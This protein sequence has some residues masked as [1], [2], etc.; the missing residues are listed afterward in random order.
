M[1]KSYLQLLGIIALIAGVAVGGV[2][3]GQHYFHHDHPP[4]THVKA[5]SL[6][7]YIHAQLNITPEQDEKLKDMER[8]YQ[9]KVIY[10]EEKL[11]LANM[12]L[13]N[14][15]KEEKR[16]GPRVEKAIADNH[17]TMGELQKATMQ[18]L[19]K[20]Q[21]VLTEEQNQKM[22]RIITDALYHQP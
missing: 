21:T 7:D 14:A 18:H 9:E 19:F 6:N 8:E 13:A 5:N 15:I 11:K 20:M 12:E 10:L 4:H 22:N 1:K 2:Y 16:Y 3:M 17:T